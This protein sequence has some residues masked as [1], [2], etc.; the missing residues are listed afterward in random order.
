MP[1]PHDF[2]VRIGIVRPHAPRAATQGV[3]RIP[4]STFVTIAKRPSYRVR[5]G[6]DH[7]SDLGSA[8]SLFLKNRTSL[9]RQT[10]TTG[11]L[12]MTRTRELP[13]VQVLTIVR[14]NRPALS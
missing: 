4:R 8:S 3:H 6:A 11:N 2:S 12:R 1:E 14:A 13:V 7:A 5:D 9:P 10:G